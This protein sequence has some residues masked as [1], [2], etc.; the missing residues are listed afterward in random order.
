LRFEKPE[1]LVYLDECGLHIRN[2]AA[3]CPEMFEDHVASRIA[4]HRRSRLL[5]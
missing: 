1:P 3:D 4:H 2:F 5:I